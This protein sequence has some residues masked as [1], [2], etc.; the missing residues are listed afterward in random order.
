MSFPIDAVSAYH[1]RHPASN[2][3]APEKIK[4]AGMMEL[5]DMRDLGSRAVMRWGSSPHARTTSPRTTYR[6]RRLFCL[7]QKSPMRSRWWLCRLTDAASPMQG[8]PPAPSAAPRFQPR[9]ACAGLAVG[10][11]PA[12]GSFEPERLL[13]PLR[14]YRSGVC[15]ILAY[16]SL[17]RHDLN[18]I[19][20][21]DPTDPVDRRQVFC[22]DKA[23]TQIGREQR[24]RIM[25][26]GDSQTH[27]QPPC[28]IKS[29]IWSQSKT[30]PMPAPPAR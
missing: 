16:F 28:I 18:A 26:D 27:N 30:W 23:C 20:T 17:F 7:W 14:S 13:T 29:C 12:G 1:L 5:V 2:E 15:S 3:T 6:S 11:R 9:P 10:G 22:Y 24:T 8:H 25:D 21:R 4:Y 19:D